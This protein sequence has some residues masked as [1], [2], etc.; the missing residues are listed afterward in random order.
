VQKVTTAGT[1]GS[2]I[3][4]FSTVTTGTTIDGTAIWTCQGPA[5]L[6]TGVDTYTFVSSLDNTQ[7]GQVLIGATSAATCQNLMDAINANASTRGT[8]FSLPTWE[9]AQCNSVNISGSSFTL[10]QKQAGTG[11]VAQVSKTGSNFSWSGSITSGG[12]SPQGSLG[13]NEGATVS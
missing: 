7:F 5:G 6:S 2:S 12:T 13:P 1:T 10:Q 11:W 8:A 9:C 4:T 3:P